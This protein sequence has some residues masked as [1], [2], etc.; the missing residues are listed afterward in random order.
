MRIALLCAFPIHPYRKQVKFLYDR[1]SSSPVWNYNLAR[2]LA[3]IPGNEVHVLTNAPLLRTRTII[4]EEVHIHFA[5]HLPKVNFWEYITLL[6]YTK[7]NFH[8]LLRKIKPDIVHGSGTDHEFAYAAVTS[9]YPSVV[10][11]HQV[12]PQLV[13]TMGYS[14]LSFPA[15]LARYEKITMRRAKYLIAI[16]RYVSEQFPGFEGKVFHIPN[17]LGE[18]FF[19]HPAS[20]EIDIVFVGRI[21]PRKHV[22]NLVQAVDRLKKDFPTLSVHIIGSGSGPYYQRVLDF[23]ESS[24]LEKQVCFRGQLPQE[25]VAGT[26]ASSKLLVIP[27]ALESFSM[28][29]AEAQALGKP[30]IATTVGA[31]PERIEDGVTGLLVAPDDIAGLAE[32]IGKVVSNSEMRREM[33]RI[34]RERTRACCH[35][36]IVAQKT[37]E[38]YN[39]ILEHA[40]AERADR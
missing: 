39:Y 23:V 13:E 17:A 30:V 24:G 12:M 14:P 32:A 25:D 34:A 9:R 7:Y 37:T 10:T 6:R 28:V 4:D 2:A 1:K 5:A 33:G 35:P 27:S 8:R 20:E 29:A 26:I 40:A 15:L 38:A 22:L 21:I 16:T 18:H 36:D 3:R 19:D 31:F 11:I